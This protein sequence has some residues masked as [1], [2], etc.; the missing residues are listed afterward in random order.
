VIA[1]EPDRDRSSAA[2]QHAGRVWLRAAAL[3]DD[4]LIDAFYDFFVAQAMRVPL[5]AISRFLLA[6]ARQAWGLERRAIAEQRWPITPPARSSSR[7]A[8]PARRLMGSLPIGP[9]K[10]ELHDPAWQLYLRAQPAA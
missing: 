6:R 2:H 10:V 8:L 4:E 7:V 5:H 1:A 3:E 9:H